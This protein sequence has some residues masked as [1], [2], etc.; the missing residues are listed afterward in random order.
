MNKAATPAGSHIYRKKSSTAS[1]PEG[2]EHNI[3]PCPG[4]CPHEPII[5]RYQSVEFLVAREDTR[6]GRFVNKQNEYS[7]DPKGVTHL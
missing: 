4:S 6:L 1:D 5:Q 2:V 3:L 7:I